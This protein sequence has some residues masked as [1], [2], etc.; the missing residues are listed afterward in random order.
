MDQITSKIL[1]VGADLGDYA[2]ST[3]T[4]GMLFLSPVR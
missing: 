3:G 1:A 4:T 2:S